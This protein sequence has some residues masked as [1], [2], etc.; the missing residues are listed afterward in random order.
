V[1]VVVSIPEK[2]T[3]PPVLIARRTAAAVLNAFCMHTLGMGTMAEKFHGDDDDDWA[4]K[5][6]SEIKALK[7]GE[8]VAT[9][10]LGKQ[11]TLSIPDPRRLAN[12]QHRGDFNPAE[13]GFKKRQMNWR[14][15]MDD[16]VITEAI[17]DSIP[18]LYT[19]AQPH[20]RG[21][22]H[23]KPKVIRST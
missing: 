6:I 9:V 16:Y 2:A 4:V 3:P 5:D 19:Q 8:L 13:Y 21:L 18:G 10:V 17:P 11:A 1:E 15:E 12:L 14:K 22:K 23:G 20:R 7:H